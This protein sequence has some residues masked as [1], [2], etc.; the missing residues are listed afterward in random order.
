MK[1]FV[2]ALAALSALG[3]GSCA[4][5]CGEIRSM[6][7]NATIKVEDFINLEPL[8]VTASG[9]IYVDKNSDVL[10]LREYHI[11]SPIMKADGTC[12]TLTEWKEGRK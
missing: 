4:I 11:L 2:V 3:L 5:K 12:L 7:I 8:V 10:Y 1:R 6:E 9:N